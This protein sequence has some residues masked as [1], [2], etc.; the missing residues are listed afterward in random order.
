MKN[1]AGKSHRSK[2]SIED[3]HIDVVIIGSNLTAYHQQQLPPFPLYLLYV[4]IRQRPISPS[5]AVRGMVEQISTIAKI[6]AFFT[7]SFSMGKRQEGMI[8]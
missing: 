6:V 8:D 4:C 5:K 3:H 1:G 2:I 7:Y